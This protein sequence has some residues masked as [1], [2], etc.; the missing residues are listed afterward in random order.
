[1]RIFRH[2]ALSN[3]PKNLTTHLTHKL[4]AVLP[5]QFFCV[6]G[7]IKMIWRHTMHSSRNDLAG[8]SLERAYRVTMYQCSG[9]I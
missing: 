5:L 2:I 9:N 1:M 7:T 4:C 6:C 8:L 3:L